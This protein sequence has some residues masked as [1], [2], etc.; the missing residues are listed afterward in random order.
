MT[1]IQ[2]PLLL[3]LLLLQLRAAPGYP[4][5]SFN[6]PNGGRVRCPAALDSLNATCTAGDPALNEPPLFCSGLGHATCEGGSLPLNPFG[7]ALKASGFA[8]NKA[9]CEADSDGDGMTNGEELGDPCCA[10]RRGDSPSKY[11]LRH[12][13]T[14]PGFADS[15][16]P[17]IASVSCDA[18]DIDELLPVTRGQT[19]AAFNPH[20]EKRFLDWR[21]RD[22]TLPS[23]E[24]VYRDFVFNFNDTSHP[25]FHIAFGEALVDQPKHLHH[26]VITGCTKHI[27][28]ELEGTALSKTPDYCLELLG[29]FAGWAPG[30]TIYDLPINAGVKIGKGVGIV[31]IAVNVH[32]TGGDLV[33]TGTVR[34]ADGIRLHYTPDLRPKTHV[35]TPLIRVVG[36]SPLSL[37]QNLKLEVPMGKKRWFLTRRCTV[38]SRCKDTSTAEVK[39]ITS[40]L[41]SSCAQ[42]SLLGF[43]TRKEVALFCPE[44][45]ASHL[46]GGCTNGNMPI[47]IKDSF[48]HAHL[49]GT[50]MYQSVTKKDSGEVI[51]LGSMRF[52]TYDDEKAIPVDSKN[53]SLVEG[54]VLS[55][56]CVYDT[57]GRSKATAFGLSTYDEM[58]LN[59]LGAEL[60]TGIDEHFGQAFNCEGYMW[61]GE[62]D[63]QTSGMDIHANRTLVEQATECWT[64]TG[65]GVDCVPLKAQLT[66][67][68]MTSATS[69]VC[70][71]AIAS[72]C[73]AC[74]E[75]VSVNAYC[76]EHPG[77]LDC[78]KAE[79]PSVKGSP[80]PVAPSGGAYEDGGQGG[81]K[82]DNHGNKQETSST[83]NNSMTAT[84]QTSLDG[85]G[86]TTTL[87][88]IP[89]AQKFSGAGGS[90]EGTPSR[91]VV[92]MAVV[93][94]LIQYSTV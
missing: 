35:S 80:V 36:R 16:Q 14:H 51:D 79:A 28:P 21:I 47:A 32:Y 61:S 29:G 3:L 11:M 43:C 57:T 49:L 8:W 13:A 87:W 66:V 44:S 71:L 9:L 63:A 84:N 56:T 27:A 2:L 53:V 65:S 70:C 83:M 82:D 23:E 67:S 22:F 6:V 86:M 24:T 18:A 37:G 78:P 75:G 15:T 77:E 17:G 91:L 33:P 93:G 38:R 55:T 69:N 19:R 41:L 62:L 64:L 48:F 1:P 31:G 4:S 88:S 94:F 7:A 42:V 74:K 76:A 92:V 58:C 89:Q 60:D 85:D 54:D 25:E 52:W 30:A 90:R 26:F 46:T 45:C 10:W 81:K 39:A 73:L 20:E 50:E 72:S 34:P 12:A 5:F 59:A 40:G 68:N